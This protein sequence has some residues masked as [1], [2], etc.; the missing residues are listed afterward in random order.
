M[1]VI[2]DRPQPKSNHTV[3]IN[4]EVGYHD[5]YLVTIL[6]STGQC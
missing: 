4:C 3:Q 6:I 2:S 1:L 5:P